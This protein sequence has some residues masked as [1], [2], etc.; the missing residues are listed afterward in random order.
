MAI[1]S[2]ASDEDITMNLSRRKFLNLV[3]GAAAVASVPKSALTLLDTEASNISL[4]D[5]FDVSDWHFYVISGNDFYI[6]G[7]LITSLPGEI[8]DPIKTHYDF[9]MSLVTEG[10]SSEAHTVSWWSKESTDKSKELSG[11]SLHYGALSKHD[12]DLLRLT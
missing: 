8:L 6:D 10:T 2:A 7:Q 4:P 12:I 3:L 11:M 5:N 9:V 1:V